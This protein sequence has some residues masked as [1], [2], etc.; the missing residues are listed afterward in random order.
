MNMKLIQS[1][2]EPKRHAH[3]VEHASL[4][5]FNMNEKK[6]QVFYHTQKSKKK[7]YSKFFYR[8]EINVK[9]ILAISYFKGQHLKSPDTSCDWIMEV[10]LLQ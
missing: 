3:M 2:P 5:Q 8:L 10:F 1:R 7:F 6:Y 4:F 9:E